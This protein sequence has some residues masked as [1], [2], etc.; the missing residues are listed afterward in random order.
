ML[1]SGERGFGRRCS[2]QCVSKE[3]PGSSA[4]GVAGPGGCRR[5]QGRH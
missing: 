4:G 3:A 5:V 1:E 2:G